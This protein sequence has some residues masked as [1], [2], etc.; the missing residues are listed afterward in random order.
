ME[1]LILGN[2]GGI[3]SGLRYNSFLVNE[4]LLVEAPPDIVP[5]IGHAQADINKIESVYISHFHGDHCFGLPFLFLTL[6][7][8]GRDRP[9]T[10]F[11]PPGGQE[12]I[13]KLFV[14]AFSDTAPG[15]RFLSEQ[16][17]FIEV[18]D[19]TQAEL[20]EGW[21][22]EFVLTEHSKTTFG[23]FLSQNT[24]G[25]FF[26]IPD[27]LWTPRFFPFLERKPDFVLA[28]MNGTGDEENPK[29]MSVKDIQENALPV[30]GN[31]TS[32]LATH[33]FEPMAM[34]VQNILPVQPGMAFKL[35]G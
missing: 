28:D 29:H 14:T 10:V 23:F 33:L 12:H 21:T 27:T 6:G 11:S 7:N 34:S 19:R 15:Y 35:G 4:T 13:L 17:N 24:T 25:G 26:Y 3:N 5:S 2:G 18:S 16:T 20:V 30:T 9:I 22:T 1:I 32:Y 31:S 8:T